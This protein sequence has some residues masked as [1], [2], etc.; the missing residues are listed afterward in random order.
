MKNALLVPIHLDALVLKNDRMVIGPMADFTRLPYSDGR[1]SF[2]P[3]I[4]NISEEILSQPFQDLGFQL[5]PGVHL[6]WALPDGLTKGVGHADRANGNQKTKGIF[7]LVP[8]RWLVTRTDQARQK[9]Q[10][11]VESDYLYPPGQGAQSSG[12]SYPYPKNS[13]NP[14]PFRYMG[15]AM[16]LA[17]WKNRHDAPRSQYLNQ[18]QSPYPLTAVGYGEPTFAALYPNCHSIFAFYDDEVLSDLNGV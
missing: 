12:I 13:Q 10:W 5:K 4:A 15:R 11:I 16:P 17:A 1:R 18:E 7:P 14:Q 2:N 6:H 3:D 8:N 9:R